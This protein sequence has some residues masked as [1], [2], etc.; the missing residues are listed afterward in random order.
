VISADTSL[1]LPDF[2]AAE[3][4]FQLLTQVAG[5]SGR[6]E[7]EGEVIIQTYRPEDYSIEAA[8]RQDY[9]E[10]YRQEIAT[11]AELNYPPFSQLTNVIVTAETE[12]KAI[13]VCQRLSDEIRP[14]A[15]EAGLEL[16]G[17][18]PAPMT[19]LRGRYRWHLLLRGPHAL[20]QP[21]LRDVLAEI[22]ESP[23]A[24]ITVDVDPVSLM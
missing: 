16:L 11:R 10:F 24:S 8:A 6:G 23:A 1:N 13:A 19:K 5:R 22:G 20:S 3:R 2:R 14:R 17:P 9:E 4:T 15:G 21:L 7:K 18:A 12:D